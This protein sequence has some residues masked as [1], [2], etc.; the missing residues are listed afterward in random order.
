MTAA[1]IY[2]RA[3][4]FFP[5]PPPPEFSASDLRK[6][7]EAAGVYFIYDADEIVYVGESLCIRNRLAN[8]DHAL[9]NRHVS[10][11]QCDKSQRRRLEAFYIGVLNPV[12]NRESTARCPTVYR[13]A[14]NFQSLTR[15]LYAFIEE[16]PGCS[17]SHLRKAT[18]WRTR[19]SLARMVID[20]MKEWRFVREEIVQTSGRAKRLYYT[21]HAEV[22]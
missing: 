7:P 9:K 16:H 17:L 8:H 10:V 20:R 21:Y 1:E 2:E 11:I 5:P 18:G 22:A 14:S 19:S 13:R 6:A 3:K 15:S 4:Y 12:L